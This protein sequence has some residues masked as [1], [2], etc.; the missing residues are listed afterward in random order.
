MVTQAHVVLQ[1]TAAFQEPPVQDEDDWGADT[2][3]YLPGTTVWMF[4]KD[5]GVQMLAGRQRQMFHDLV[6]YG[7]QAFSHHFPKFLPALST[8]LNEIL[9]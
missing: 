5:I 1:S 8:I 3:T 9:T 4:D 6:S 7:D 2:E